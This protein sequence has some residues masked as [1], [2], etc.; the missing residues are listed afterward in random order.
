MFQWMWVPY[1]KHRK[2]WFFK[3]QAKCGTGHRYLK[4]RQVPAW[5]AQS[6][7]VLCPRTTGKEMLGVVTLGSWSTWLNVGFKCVLRWKQGCPCSLLASS[8]AQVPKALFPKG[9]AAAA[10]ESQES[11]GTAAP[12][13]ALGHHVCVQGVGWEAL[14]T[15]GSQHGAA[16]RREIQS[17]S[18]LPGHSLPL[19]GNRGHSCTERPPENSNQPFH[20]DQGLSKFWWIE[21]DMPNFN[22][23]QRILSDKSGCFTGLLSKQSAFSSRL[24]LTEW[25]L[26]L[27]VNSGV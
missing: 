17:H 26:N 21:G 27:A 10:G 22:C 6:F 11:W 23:N 19:R 5:Q 3:V 12:G 1:L 7:F 4:E 18:S 20:L 9:R 24:Q 2:T 8:G 13:W 25:K 16:A 14:P 15:V